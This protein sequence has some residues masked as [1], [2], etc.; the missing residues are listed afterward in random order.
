MGPLT[1]NPNIQSI[2][3]NTAVKNGVKKEENGS[4]GDVLNQS[5]NSVDQA[6]KNADKMISNLASG[7]KADIHN[8]MIAVEK[9]DIG[10]Q[11]MMQI[12]NKLVSAYQEVYRMQV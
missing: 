6:E 12:R 1:F 9:A 2:N 5:I 11:L 3:T 8:T 4:F 7:H 10:F